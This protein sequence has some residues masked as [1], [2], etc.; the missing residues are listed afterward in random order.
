MHPALR[1]S[2]KALER[3][4]VRYFQP[5]SGERSMVY[6]GGHRG[7]DWHDMC[8]GQLWPIT[9]SRIKCLIIGRAAAESPEEQGRLGLTVSTLLL[10]VCELEGESE[11]RAFWGTAE[12]WCEDGSSSYHLLITGV[13]FEV[14]KTKYPKRRNHGSWRRNAHHSVWRCPLGLPAARGFRAE[15]TP[16]S[17]KGRTSR[18]ELWGQSCSA[19][20]RYPYW[21]RHLPLPLRNAGE[22][23]CSSRS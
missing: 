5:H 1:V 21:V 18:C 2:D 10:R 3:Q 16:S 7:W 14:G 20:L 6:V 15:K 23:Y 11:Q 9:K 22:P 12:L 13:C 17:V 19:E 4:E 8:V